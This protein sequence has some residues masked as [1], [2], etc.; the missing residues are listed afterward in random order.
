MREVEFLSF[1]MLNRCKPSFFKCSSRRINGI[2][3]SWE[4]ELLAGKISKVGGR[5]SQR[6]FTFFGRPAAIAGR[7]TTPLLYKRKWMRCIDRWTV[8]RG[9]VLTVQ[10]RGSFS[11]VCR[12]MSTTGWANTMN[13]FFAASWNYR[14]RKPLNVVGA[15]HHALRADIGPPFASLTRALRG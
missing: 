15:I 7:I 13:R 14:Q 9:S 5:V 4:N 1:Q 12:A 11:E 3:N 10:H 6:L 2:V 8:I